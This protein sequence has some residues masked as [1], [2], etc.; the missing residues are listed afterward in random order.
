MQAF[1]LAGLVSHLPFP[2]LFLLLADDHV[3]GV[4]CTYRAG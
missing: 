1:D 2:T 4:T 3:P